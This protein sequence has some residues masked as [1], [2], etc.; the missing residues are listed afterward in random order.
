ML[1]V[2]LVEDSEDDAELILRALHKANGFKIVHLR[3][4]NEDDFKQAL[5]RHICDIIICD[6]ALPR[7]SA[8]RVLE[9]I[10][11]Y[12]LDTPVILVSGKITQEQADK[13][14][15]RNTVIAFVSK[16]N[17][18]S[19][20]VLFRREVQLSRRYDQMLTSWAHALGL[21][22]TETREHSERV[23]TM[24]VQLA[25][26]MGI[27][28]IEIIHMRRGALMHDVGKMGVRDEILLKPGP[29]DTQEL[30]QMRKHPQHG[31][32][33]LITNEWMQPILEIPYCHHEHWN[34]SGYPRGL[35]GEEIPIA[36]R[37]FAVVDN[38]DALTSDRPY[39][40]AWSRDD[41]LKYIREQSGEMFDP[42]VVRVFLEMMSAHDAQ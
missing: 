25:R 1:R 28:E 38:Y 4:D 8:E 19:L 40:V 32:D 34:G 3:V 16:D 22:D 31:Y 9:L 33:L 30:Y 20:S 42:E 36:A 7:F 37:I 11:G 10:E 5:H 41:A 24:T 6:Y 21:R 17:L 15:G 35:K 29:L 2:L 13:V 23:T 39:R 26:A 12:R 27:S 18:S 14:L